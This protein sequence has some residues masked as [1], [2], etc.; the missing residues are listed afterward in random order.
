MTAM[1]LDSITEKII[2]ILAKKFEADPSTIRAETRLAEDL[3]VDSF[4]AVEL[5]F[6][7]EEAF[8]L[9]VPD[10]EIEHIRTVG[11]V[12]KYILEW[13]TKNPKA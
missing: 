3:G 8:G 7:V 1:T 2:G 10:S 11:D 4:G 5:M 6:E 13:T 9:K 12:S